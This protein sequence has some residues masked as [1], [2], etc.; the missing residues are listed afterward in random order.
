ME[1]NL[2]TN[3][4]E[5][6]HQLRFFFITIYLMIITYGVMSSLYNLHKELNEGINNL[7]LTNKG[8]NNE[9]SIY[10]ELSNK[11]NCLAVNAAQEVLC[12]NKLI[13]QP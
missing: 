9:I 6:S 12:L 10:Q 1:N 2:T 11:H 13:K 7:I 8:L 5:F 3:T 4:A